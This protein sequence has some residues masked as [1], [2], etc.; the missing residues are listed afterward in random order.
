MTS[1]GSGKGFSLQKSEQLVI[2]KPGAFDKMQQS[3]VLNIT[4]SSM[5]ASRVFL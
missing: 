1:G 5:M 2:L 4:Q 3:P